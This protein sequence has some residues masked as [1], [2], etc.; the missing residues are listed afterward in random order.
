MDHNTSTEA[1]LAT[2]NEARC[3]IR[4]ELG[5]YRGLAVGATYHIPVDPVKS[6]EAVAKLFGSA[7]QACISQHAALGVVLD[8]ADTDKPRFR[9][10]MR[11]DLRNH[12]F[13]I[14][15]KQGDSYETRDTG[16]EHTESL[17]SLLESI[18]NAEFDNVARVP[19]WRV[20]VNPLGGKAGS[21]CY[22]VVFH[23]SHSHGDGTSGLA[24]HQ[25]LSKTLAIDR[26]M[27]ECIMPVELQ[28]SAAELPPV[29]DPLPISWRYLL[30]AVSKEYFPP[31][32]RRLLGTASTEK[33]AW[34]GS[35]TS[36]DPSTFKSSLE[37]VRLPAGDLDAVIQRCRKA[38][39]KLT[40]L[41]VVLI[42]R[43]LSI[44][45]RRVGIEHEAL[46][47]STA[48]SLRSLF[49][50][51]SSEMGLYASAVNHY[52]THDN[53]GQSLSDGE[54]ACAQ[55]L[56]DKLSK[57]SKSATD[58]PV[59]LLPYAS[60]VKQWLQSK[61]GKPR[62][63]SFEVSNIMS[64]DCEANSSGR[65]PSQIQI[66]DMYFAQPADAIGHP[67]SFNV[68]SLRGGDLVIMCCWQIGALG[69]VQEG[70]SPSALHAV[71][72]TEK[73]F[74]KAVARNLTEEFDAWAS[75]EGHN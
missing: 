33:P 69:L 26:D 5:Y 74:M 30:A 50:V 49:G 60:S 64:F 1:R 61:Y 27:K 42:A 55:H 24:F 29:M 28:T 72:K 75:G 4:H 40:G 25:S 15:K 3:I 13:V 66:T 58:Q 6:F 44:E 63:T 53:S 54:I 18:V 2:L 17:T 62:E 46:V 56:T 16:F 31:S 67:I 9:K 39:M 52:Y 65:Q 22:R 36:F 19:P 21:S 35:S 48:I 32:F 59:G 41:L 10:L 7:L 23:Y 20:Y 8:D 47:S 68:V 12:L 70:Q 45:L 73:A 43:S 71:A 37:E 51:K 11:L 38:Q 57:S 34:V 14:P